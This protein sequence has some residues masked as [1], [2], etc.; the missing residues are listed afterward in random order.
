MINRKNITAR[1]GW[2]AF[3]LSGMLFV[4]CGPAEQAENTKDKVDSGIQELNEDLR[5]DIEK[6]KAALTADLERLKVRTETK[7]INFEERLRDDKLTPAERKELEDAHKEM[8][9]QLVR[10]EV[11]TSNV[12]VATRDSWLEVK[13]ESSKVVDDIDNWFERQAEKMD[14]KTDAD[15]DGDGH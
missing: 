8:K 7:T 9:G 11:A 3:M 14:K 15:R 10:I 5:A 1:L 12:G 2:P 4:G 6:D 13:D